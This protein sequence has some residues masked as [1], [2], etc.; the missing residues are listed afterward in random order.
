VASGSEMKIAFLIRSSLFLFL[1]SCHMPLVTS[2]FGPLCSISFNF[3]I[4][5]SS[6]CFSDLNR[7]K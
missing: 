2:Y 4:N 1:V 7:R 5:F 6:A 3:G